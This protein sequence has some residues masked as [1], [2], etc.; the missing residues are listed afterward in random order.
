MKVKEM[1]HKGLK[2]LD[3][4][5]PAAQTEI[6]YRVYRQLCM[7]KHGNPLFQIHHGF[8][9]SHDEVIAMNGPNISESSVRASWFALE[10]AAALSF[11]ALSSFINTYLSVENNDDLIEQVKM[12]GVRRK[13]LEVEAY[14]RWGAED[15]FPGK[16]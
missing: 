2:N 6:E 8:I 14:K 16:W 1:I 9:F 3:H 13:E 11:I 12:I 5:D 7:A 4:P 10:H 15:P